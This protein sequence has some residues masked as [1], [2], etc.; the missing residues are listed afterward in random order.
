MFISALKGRLQYTQNQSQSLSLISWMGSLRC[1]GWRR[2][3][4]DSS[5]CNERERERYWSFCSLCFLLFHTCTI[6]P[7]SKGS[8]LRQGSK[9][10][11]WRMLSTDRSAQVMQS[12]ETSM[13]PARQPTHPHP[14]VLFS[15]N[16]NLKI[17]A[18]RPLKKDRTLTSCQSWHM[19]LYPELCCLSQN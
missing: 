2:R 15:W 3:L 19:K 5:A 6:F 16:D 4:R 12:P 17:H 14:K 9:P 1:R 8:G 7:F 11:K 13:N 18:P 10:D